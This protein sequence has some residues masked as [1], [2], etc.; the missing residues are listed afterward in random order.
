MDA[1]LPGKRKQP[2][3][4]GRVGRPP[5]AASKKNGYLQQRILAAEA[6]VRQLKEAQAQLEDDNAQAQPRLDIFEVGMKAADAHM[7]FLLISRC[8]FS[9]QTRS[10]LALEDANQVINKKGSVL[11]ST[12]AMHIALLLDSI[13]RV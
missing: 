13:P 10:V 4:A 2:A 11:A 8:A 12:Q 1:A 6:A 9:R 7:S 3:L 5:N